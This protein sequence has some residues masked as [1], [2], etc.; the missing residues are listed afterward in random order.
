MNLAS[1]TNTFSHTS[2]G[3]S[4]PPQPSPDVA[5]DFTVVLVASCSS[6]ALLVWHA[7]QLSLVGIAVAVGAMVG[8]TVGATEGAVVG[9]SVGGCGTSVAVGGLGGVGVGEA[10]AAMPNPM[11]NPTNKKNK[12]LSIDNLPPKK[13]RG[14]QY[15]SPRNRGGTRRQVRKGI[16]LE[17]TA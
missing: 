8:A 5:S 12:R 9:A 7:T 11:L 17:I 15:C 10:Q 1:L 6:V 4:S 2:S 3:G 16:G 14:E 13:M